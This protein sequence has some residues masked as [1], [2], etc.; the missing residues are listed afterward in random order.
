MF[1]TER[2]VSSK[3]AISWWP[4]TSPSSR[5][6]DEG[7]AAEERRPGGDAA[8]SDALQQRH[9]RVGF[10]RSAAPRRRA[11]GRNDDFFFYSSRRRGR[12]E[13]SNRRRLRPKKRNSGPHRPGHSKPNALRANPATTGAH[14]AVMAPTKTL[15]ATYWASITVDDA[16]DVG[17]RADAPADA[18]W[19]RLLGRMRRRRQFQIFQLKEG[20]RTLIVVGIIEFCFIQFVSTSFLWSILLCC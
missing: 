19:R 12:T 20:S 18:V 16:I 2:K 17:E 14:R 11:A 10:R 15:S 7:G 9:Q 6:V 1:Q 13:T 5:A 3:F 8:V 4:S